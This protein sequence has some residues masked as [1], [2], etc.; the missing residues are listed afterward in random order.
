LVTKSDSNVWHAALF[1]A[2]RNTIFTANNFFSNRSGV[3]RPTLLRNTFG[4]AFSGPI[5]KDRAFFF[6]S[7]EGR[8]DASQSAIPARTVPLSGLGHGEV[9]FLGCGPAVP[10]ANCGTTVTPT[11]RH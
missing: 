5:K 8:R 10:A 1:E 11:P 3:P 9:K 6:Y 2:H 7:Y 4:G